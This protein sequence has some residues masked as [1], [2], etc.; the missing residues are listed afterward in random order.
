MKVFQLTL[1]IHSVYLTDFMHPLYAQPP[2]LFCVV[3]FF[4]ILS[5]SRLHHEYISQ[6]SP[7]AP[8][9]HAGGGHSSFE[10]C[11]ALGGMSEALQ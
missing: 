7:Q 4:L 5:L 3:V 10:Q 8:V 11:S 9:I 1:I 2:S 6:T